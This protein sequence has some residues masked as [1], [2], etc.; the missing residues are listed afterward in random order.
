MK[1]PFRIENKYDRMLWI[2]LRRLHF[3]IDLRCEK[4]HLKTR[5]QGEFARRSIAQKM[6]YWRG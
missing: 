2:A 3:A 1:P 5:K 6:R 4:E